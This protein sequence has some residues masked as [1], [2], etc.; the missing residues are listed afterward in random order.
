MKRI[1]IL[2]V[3]AVVLVIPGLLARTAHAYPQFV[4]KGLGDCG[5]CHHSPSGGGFPNRWGRES[6]DVTFGKDSGVGFG[7]EDLTYDPARPSRLAVD[8]GV[9]VRLVPMFGTDGDGSLGPTV[10]PMLTELGGAVAFGRWM[11]YG[12][13]TARKIE[14]S[15]AS[16]VAFSREHWLDY[17]AA[18]GVDIRAGRLVLPFGIRQPDHTQYT[19]EDFGFDKYDQSYGLELDLRQ[20]GWS[21]YGG[22]FA[23]DLTHEPS[24]R[25][26][27]S[28]VVT[29]TLE[30]GS[31]AAVGLSLLGAV[32]TAADRFAGSVF[33]RAP[34]GDHAYALAE[35]ALQHRSAN[36]ADAKLSNIG[37]YL[38]VGWFARPEMDVFVEAGHRAL[39]DADGLTKER[40]GLG[41][42]WQVL[43]WFE[44]APQAFVEARTDLPTRV[45]ALA[46]LHLTY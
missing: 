39:L 14:G 41:M 24:E 38:R 43:R 18:T 2:L 8:L 36:D 5:S 25:Q 44:F 28:V 17:R 29:P 7:N 4:F 3:V 42:N 33:A 37:E 30:L 10:I 11:I 20:D 45:I 21:L 40:V 22:V 23:G 35:V 32:S 19:R 26:E 34:L 31:G 1:S 6:L 9:D 12:T 13:A 27:R 46:Q 15:G 16:Y